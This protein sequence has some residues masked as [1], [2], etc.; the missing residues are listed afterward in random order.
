MQKPHNLEPFDKRSSWTTNDTYVTSSIKESETMI[1]WKRVYIEQDNM[2]KKGATFFR[3]ANNNTVADDLA[4]DSSA[5]FNVGDDVVIFWKGGTH[6]TTVTD[7]PG[8]PV[9]YIYLTN[10]G[11]GYTNTPIVQVQDP[12][13][14]GVQA[15]AQA[16]MSSDGSRVDKIQLV[17]GAWGGGHGYT[18]IPSVTIAPPGTPAGVQAQAVAAIGRLSLASIPAGGV[19][20]WAG[21]RLAS[22]TTT[23]TVTRSLLKDAFGEKPDGSDGGAFIEF[24]DVPSNANQNVPKYTA[25]PNHFQWIEYSNYWFDNSVHRTNNVLYHLAA[26]QTFRSSLKGWSYSVNSPG[27][28]KSL[29]V[30]FVGVIP[31]VVYREETSVHEIG[32]RFG[33]VKNDYPYIDTHAD[34]LNHDASDKC[35][36]SYNNVWT[37]GITE[38]SLDVI[39]SGQGGH[40]GL[41]NFDDK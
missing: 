3:P 19:P 40:P 18:N 28:V 17:G 30:V 8:S 35:V 14:G 31:S 23:F 7:K 27:N 4:V 16:V 29:S 13:G 21:I 37:N 1:A 41:R 12:G 32:H 6:N 33:L 22:D 11:S 34:V 5:D 2:Y 20:Q 9:T 25:F 38:F 39:Y 15:Q 26:N 36:M 10:R 24:L